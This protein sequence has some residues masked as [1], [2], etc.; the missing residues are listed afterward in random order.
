MWGTKMRLTICLAALAASVAS[1][2]PALAQSATAA[3]EAKGTVLQSLTLI[4]QSNLDF[5]TVAPDALNTGTVSIDAD[6]NTRTTGGSVVALPG[7]FTRARFDGSGTAGNLVELVLTQPAGGVIT[8]GANSLGAVLAL[9]SAGTSRTIPAGGTF[10]AYVG[11]TFSIA[12]NQP[13]G[14][15]SGQFDLTANYQ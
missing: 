11:G 9:D 13:S 1:A 15:Y 6:T 7:P 8:N 14:V 10:S 4:N 3:A 5:G 12:A 2:S